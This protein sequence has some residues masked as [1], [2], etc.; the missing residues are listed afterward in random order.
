[1]GSYLCVYIE[2]TGLREE[3]LEKGLECW[4]ERER[5]RVMDRTLVNFTFFLVR[6]EGSISVWIKIVILLLDPSSFKIFSN[7]SLFCSVFFSTRL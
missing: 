6:L 3:S 1:M 7:E 4:R 5:E 2:V